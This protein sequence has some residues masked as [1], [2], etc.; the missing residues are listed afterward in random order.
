V[1]KAL[2]AG[3]VQP[4]GTKYFARQD[5]APLKAALFGK[6]RSNIVVT[7]KLLCR[8]SLRAAARS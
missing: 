1:K 4:L 6:H 2:E 5:E 3:S 8:V 7:G